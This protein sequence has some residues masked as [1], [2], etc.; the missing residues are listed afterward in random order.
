MCGI[1]LVP[2]WR[3]LFVRLFIHVTCRYYLLD[4]ESFAQRVDCVHLSI[5]FRQPCAVFASCVRVTLAYS[6]CDVRSYSEVPQSRT[7]HPPI[8]AS[9]T[10]CISASLMPSQP[11]K[12]SNTQKRSAKPCTCLCLTRITGYRELSSSDGAC[13]AN[14]SFGPTNSC[15]G[16]AAHQ[17][18]VRS[19]AEAGTCSV[20]CRGKQAFHLHAAAEGSFR[21]VVIRP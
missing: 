19:R 5:D 7:E 10:S 4:C 9:P 3:S 16:L 6:I 1:R 21:A 18:I 15:T 14:E 12:L 20:F 2:S 8:S 11:S 13:K 17:S